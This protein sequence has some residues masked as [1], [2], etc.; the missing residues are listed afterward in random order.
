MVKKE[1]PLSIVNLALKNI[2]VEDSGFS[3]YAKKFIEKLNKNIEGSGISAVAVLGGSLAKGTFLNDGFDIDVFV[4][5][6]KKYSDDELSDILEK[7]LKNKGLK[8][9]RVHGS[10]DYF[11]ITDKKV[12]EIVPVLKVASWK[13][14]R[15]VADMSPLHVYYFN[16]KAGKDKKIRNQIRLT[17]M[18]MKSAGVYGAESYIK[19]FSGHVADILILQHGTFLNLVKKASKWKERTII[20]IEKHQK[21]PEMTMNESK[22]VSPL[23]VVDPVQEDRNASAALSKENYLLFI[24]KCNEF[25]KKPALDYFRIKSFKEKISENL[26]KIKEPVKSFDISITP[27][28]GKKDVVGSKIMKIKEFIEVSLEKN[29]FNI[30]Y[31]EWEF[32]PKKARILFSVKNEALSEKKIHKGPKSSMREHADAFKKKYK[33][34]FVKEGVFYAKVKRKYVHPEDFI[35]VIISD[36]YVKEKCKRI[37]FKML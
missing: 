25:L 7:V 22:I 19:G 14:A 13:E 24:K 29:D 35:K 11:Q 30:K 17:K 37:S 28:D 15:N 31:A 6:D 12:F 1:T 3:E 5:F 2:V 27:L 9:V 8:Y 20:D 4:R 21:H 18:F 23:I 34:L 16:K 33:E 26:R 36:S 10:R 32:N